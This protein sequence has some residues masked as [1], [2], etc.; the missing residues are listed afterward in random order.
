MSFRT[1][2]EFIRNKKKSYKNN[3][4]TKFK[5]VENKNINLS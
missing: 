2:T 4:N 3:R 1:Q 5:L